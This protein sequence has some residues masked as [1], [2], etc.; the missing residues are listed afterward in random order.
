MGM[1]L[2]NRGR[3]RFCLDRE[4]CQVPPPRYLAMVFSCYPG[5]TRAQ[6]VLRGNKAINGEAFD[7]A[8]N[9]G[10]GE[11]IRTVNPNLGKVTVPNWWCGWSES[12]RHSSRNR[13]F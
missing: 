2:L 8:S 6:F 10:A 5:V 12:S 1:A 9:N 4:T 11:R 13:I 3:R 7:F